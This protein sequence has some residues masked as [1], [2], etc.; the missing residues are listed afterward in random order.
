M[1]RVSTDAPVGWP[2]CHPLPPTL[3]LQCLHHWH[4]QPL[5]TGM[6]PAR[7]A[8][9]A[10]WRG[11]SFW[12]RGGAQGWT[13]DCVE[14]KIPLP[15]WSC[16]RLLSFLCRGFCYAITFILG[17]EGKRGFKIL[18]KSSWVFFPYFFALWWV[19]E[20]SALVST[21]KEG[22]FPPQENTSQAA[23]LCCS[24]CS[25]PWPG[26]QR[27]WEMLYTTSVEMLISSFNFFLSW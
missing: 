27:V 22:F 23:V 24:D 17:T 10:R 8:T 21:W 11:K 14:S 16:T 6:S 9:M 5:F 2:F 12:G 26:W 15:L 13:R 3:H 18:F 25:V 7:A 4:W 20:G 1:S 19:S